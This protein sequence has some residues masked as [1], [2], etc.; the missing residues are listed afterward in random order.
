MVV[1]RKI[2]WEGFTTFWVKKLCMETRL[3]SALF[4]RYILLFFFGFDHQN[5]L[6]LH[7]YSK[8]IEN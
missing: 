3:A 6:W 7:R 8:Y 4:Q 2:F 5:P 1:N